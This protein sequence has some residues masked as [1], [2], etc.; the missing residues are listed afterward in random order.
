MNRRRF[1]LT[2]LASLPSACIVQP[3]TRHASPPPAA[4]SGDRLV[5][6]S[7]VQRLVIERSDPVLGRCRYVAESRAERIAVPILHARRG[8]LFDATVENML[9]QP[10]TVHFHGLAMPE[11]EDGAGFDPIAPGGRKHVRFQVNNRSG[12]YWIHAHPHGLTAQQVYGGLYGMLIVTDE[13][14]AALDAALGLVPGNRIALA[15][16]DARV[17]REVVRPYA[18]TPDDCLRGWYGNR[19]LVNGT[20]H[21]RFQ[22]APGWVRLQLLNTCNARG[23]LLAFKDGEALLPFHLLGTDGGL[24]R[25]PRVVDRL[26]VYSA[27]RVDVCLNV[28]GRRLVSAISLPFDPRHQVKAVTPQ[29]R[30]PARERYESLA[31]ASVCETGG[32]DPRFGVSDGAELSLFT[33]H[34][35]E[36]QAAPAV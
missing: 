21:A 10:T 35:K 36:M 15:L 31:L 24:L 17:D 28:A 9:P 22:V 16:A 33:L 26:F 2:T 14:D 12:M 1:V 27:E 20:L 32:S 4:L 29:Y 23:L 11:A 34:V 6:L 25:G 3:T 30:H 19:M 18:P 13:D 7:S 5:G 8:D